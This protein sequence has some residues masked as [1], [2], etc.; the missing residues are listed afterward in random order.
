MSKTAPLEVDVVIVGAGIAGLMLF[1]K[2]S[3]LGVRVALTEKKASVADGPSTRNEGWLHRGTYHAT[4]IKDRGQAVEVARRC[5]YGYEQIRSYAPEAVEEVGC[6]AIA[7]L[8][9]GERCNEVVSRWK[10]AGVAFQGLTLATTRRMAPEIRI[11]DTATA[12]LVQDLGINSRILYAKLLNEGMRCGGIFFNNCEFQPH[13]T[14]GIA[15][16]LLPNGPIEI[17]GRVIVYT[18][19]YAVRELLL[20]QYQIDVPIRYWKSHL[21][22][23]P[24]LS[25]PSVFCVD[26]GEA[27]MMN[28]GEF[29]IVGLNQDAVLCSV[30][31][32]E[33]VQAN[34]AAIYSAVR[35]LFPTADLTATLPV[36]CIKTDLLDP[37]KPDRSLNIGIMEPQPGLICAIPGKMTEAPFLTDRLVSLI[38]DRL[39]A[40]CVTLRPVDR[41]SKSQHLDLPIRRLPVAG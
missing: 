15:R 8:L 19:G 2:L 26:A 33:P 14:G 22:I 32:V 11:A 28:H 24:R 20:Q 18:C 17:A 38:Y 10:E 4:S 1:K 16:I 30:P 23:T 27:A 21:L 7:L 3:A 6:E 41:L 37:D 36:A 39:E 13:A 5:V 12:F 34:V 31:D 40:T 25:K 9:G 29:S 35:R